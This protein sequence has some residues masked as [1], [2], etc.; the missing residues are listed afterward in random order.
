M[1]SKRPWILGLLEELGYESYWWHEPGSEPEQ[2][3]KRFADLVPGLSSLPIGKERLYEHQYQV[4]LALGQGKNVVL[5]ARTGSGKTEAW[6]LPL[7]ANKWKA[8]VVYPTLAL[9]ADQIRRLEEYTA[10]TGSRPVV[11]IDRPSIARSKKQREKM[12]SML[13]G[14]GIVVTNPAFLLAELKR[15]AVSPEKS[16]LKQFL[17]DIDLVVIDE[18]DFYGPRSAHLLLKTVELIVNHLAARKPRIVVLSATLGNPEELAALLTRING[19]ESVVIEGEPFH[20][21]NY[22]VVVLGKN[23]ESLKKFIEQ[24]R[25]TIGAS[26]AKWVLS[27]LE[28][29][30]V[31]RE[32]LYEV[33]SALEAI[34]LRPPRLGLSVE[35]ILAGIVEREKARVTLVFAK[36]IRHAERIYRAL[37][38]MV[39]PEKRRLIA[40]HHHLVSK[41]RREE[42]EE[43]TRRGSLRVVITVRTLAQGI[44][45]GSIARIVH[46]GLPLDLREYLQREGRKGRRKTLQ[47]TETV[48]IPSGLWD[49]RLLERG[50][51]ALREWLSLPLE[52]LFINPRHEYAL[53]F[54]GLWKILRGIRPSREE[55]RVLER[56]GFV[57]KGVDAFGREKYYVNSR[58][59][60]FWNEIG[61]YE[62]G[63][64]YGYRKVLL[65]RWGGE[66]PLREEISYRDAVEKYQPG[67]YDPMSETMVVRIDPSTRRIYLMQVEDA[68]ES[69][70]WLRAAA[71]RYEDV[72]REWGE[73]PDIVSDIKYGRLY[74]AVSLNVLAPIEGFGELVEEPLDVE[75]IIESRR[76][77]L[78]SRGRKLHVYREMEVIGLNAPV[79]GRYRD[80]T[81]GYVFEDSSGLSARNLRIGLATLLAFL[82]LYPT[83]SLSLGL[84]RYQ[85]SSVGGVRVI[86]LWESEAAGILD[87]IDWLR[88]AESLEKTRPRLLAGVLMAAVDPVAAYHV[89]RGDVVLEDAYRYAAIVART[90]S[91]YRVVRK[92]FV[93]I[94]V[95]R[96]SRDHGIASLALL[97]E[98]VAGRILASI[99]WYDGSGQPGVELVEGEPGAVNREVV[100][101]LLTVIDRLASE[102]YT[103]YYYGREQKEL[104]QRLSFASFFLREALRRLEADGKLKDLAMALEEKYGPLPLLS[105]VRPKIDDYREWLQRVSREGK[106]EEA[107]RALKYLAREM[108]LAVYD[109]ALA[110]NYNGIRVR[111][112]KAS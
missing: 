31:F 66:E 1:V 80:Y 109:T 77:R 53:V 81:Y 65:A 37:L 25:G 69:V 36:S 27:V 67:A 29:D 2:V 88:V 34:G 61:F 57:E 103:I 59:K 3:E 74:T 111:A 60:R 9:S 99:A 108:V 43:A 11:R 15:I 64:P 45:I 106:R 83:L 46:V 94:T 105:H 41:E 91:G 93:E 90:V 112:T 16:I 8:L 101:K 102:D 87:E 21:E 49:R 17:S 98:E 48:I 63:P 58:G 92:G 14:A 18:L 75:W 5:T 85:V 28:D 7:L 76:P 42:I 79:A 38:D 73:L 86:H 50:A 12:L 54:A 97:H 107:A 13:A 68:V 62:H 84:L 70:E 6:V 24:N 72:K 47:Y 82:R 39:G 4:F 104:L 32:H 26:D 110:L 95:P 20:V 22:T 40:V 96:H 51:S 35:E 19:R 33:Y 71:A 23:V 100:E 56:L 44:D 10:A 78:R 55:L 52:K 89:L 30:D